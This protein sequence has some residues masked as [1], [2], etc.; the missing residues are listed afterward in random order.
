MQFFPLP[1]QRL[2]RC[3]SAAL[4]LATLSLSAQ[5]APSPKPDT[6]P[7]MNRSLSPDQRAD[8]VMKEM[9]LDEKMNFVHGTGW[10][11][12]RADAEIP[13]G[14]LG[15]AGYVQGVPR[16]GIPGINQADS[17]VGIRLAAQGSHYA[18]LLPSV[19]AAACSWDK[20]ALLLFGSVLGRELRD[21]G[22]NMSIGGGVD[23]ARDPRNG[24]NFEYAGEDPVLAGTMV[25]ELAS[26]VQSNQVMGD[27]KHYALNDQET[28]RTTVNVKID[29]RAAR[30]SDLLAFQI[31]IGMAHPA[32]VM[33]S[34]NRVTVTPVEST[35]DW[36]C[37]SDYLLNQV[38][39]KDF[40]FKGFVVSDWGG[41]H[42]TVKAALAGLDQEQPGS[43]Y[44]G[45]PLKAAVESNQVP[46]SR[47]DDAVHRV[48][49]SMF[50]NG[51]IDNPPVTQ[52]P[53]PF[54][55]RDDA[56]HIA[57]E[58]IVLLKNTDH[59]LPLNATSVASIA[60][61][62]SHA[63]VG[64]LSGGG[65]AQV[66][67][68]GGNVASVH[69]HPG[70]AY[71]METVYFPSSPLKEIRKHA[72]SAK[73]E[74]DPGTDPA[75]A[76]KLAG[77]SQIAIVFVNQP[78]SEGR[79]ASTIALPDHQDALVD[80]VAAANSHTIVVLENGGPVSMPWADRVHA[81]IEAWYPGIGG[82][83]SLANILFGDVNPSGRLAITFAKTDDQ[84]PHPEVAGM[85][86]IAHPATAGRHRPG[87]LPLFDYDATESVR[88][89]YKWFESEHKDP[90]FPFGFGLSYTSY[91][92]SGLSASQHEVSFTVRNSG[93][94][95]G[96]EVAQVYAVLPASTGE[97]TFKRLIAWDRVA[98]APGE[99][100]TVTLKLDPLYLSIFDLGKNAF[101]LAPGD[102]TIL[103]GSSSADTPL[104]ATVH[105]D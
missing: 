80:A 101:T 94:R 24:R 45:D 48:L 12:L 71:W 13:K 7:W 21:M 99:S 9:T 63:D 93:S 66:D 70:G 4:F 57:D 78:M 76:A 65:S 64:V 49:R 16:L 19:L 40:D 11:G 81:I 95:A 26:G 104:T 25:G 47:L 58:S 88:V 29:E 77:T 39:K 75:A 83:Q 60:L 2:L 31:A 37:E 102:Y 68:P 33:C 52:V 22:Y 32:A 6:R 82:A 36:A 15:G 5:M 61:I 14:S 23:L 1:T 86:L 92:Y 90:L 100:K 79:D 85:D 27:I 43:Q 97:S 72:P 28:G 50:A 8:L 87:E 10:N 69:P 41:T 44:F 103:A 55:G 74:F 3:F 67:P 17:A 89:G 56:E 30:E 20:D 98:L 54:R 38:L 91:V 18:T 73:I 42:S 96:T 46:M 62:G 51:L 53:D 35:P 59:A 105:I 84:L 34:Y